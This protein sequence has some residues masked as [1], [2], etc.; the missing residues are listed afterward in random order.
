MNYQ[1]ALL[2][3]YYKIGSVDQVVNPDRPVCFGVELNQEMICD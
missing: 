2:C 3:E 1:G